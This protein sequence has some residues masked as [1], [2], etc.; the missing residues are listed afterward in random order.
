MHSAPTSSSSVPDR[1]ARW[2]RCPLSP[3][4]LT[5]LVIEAEPLPRYKS[6][7]GALV[8]RAVALIP[9][10]VNIPWERQF[11][12]AEMVLHILSLRFVAKGGA[13]LAATVMR[14]AF[15]DALV[16]AAVAQGACSGRLAGFAGCATAVATSR[17]KPI[18]AT[19]AP[20][21]SLPPTAPPA[22][23]ACARNAGWSTPLYTVPALAWEVEVDEATLERFGSTLRFDLGFIP[24]GYASPRRCASAVPG[25]RVVVHH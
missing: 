9:S 15:D 22:P 17:S 5:V 11:L 23:P 10:S 19:C 20:V 12:R 7:G 18:A 14:S 4:V 16:K 24:E 21:S 8:P 6:C 13:P 3:R 2:P 1:R 25:N